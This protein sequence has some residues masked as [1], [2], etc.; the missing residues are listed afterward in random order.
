MPRIERIRVLVGRQELFH[1]SGIR[2][3]DVGRDVRHEEA[4]LA[5]HLRQQHARV[6]ADAVRDQM[7]VERFLRIAG[8]SHQPAHVARRER[9]GVLRP[10][11][12]GWVEGPIRDH[13]LHRHAAARDRRV[14]LVGELHA[15][16]GTAREYARTARRCAVRDAQL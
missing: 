10:E 11:I 13:H 1:L 8:P 2:Q 9:V 3:L 6:L 7:V 15:D 4:I 5:D 14:Q 12:A 16:A